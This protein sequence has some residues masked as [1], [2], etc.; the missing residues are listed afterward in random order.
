MNSKAILSFAAVAAFATAAA[1][2]STAASAATTAS[3]NDGD[4][5]QVAL[6]AD[7]SRPRAEVKTEAATV[8]AKASYEGDPAPVAALHSG[9]DAKAVRAEAARA[10]RLGQIRSGEI[11]Q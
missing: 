2:A 8:H 10:D 5:W 1:V 6:R 7:Q 9:L 11:A 3:A 4:T